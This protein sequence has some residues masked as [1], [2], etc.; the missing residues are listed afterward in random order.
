[1]DKILFSN[2]DFITNKIVNE[3]SIE[4]VEKIEELNVNCSE[5]K[6][7]LRRC[8]IRLLNVI[9]KKDDKCLF[10]TD[11]IPGFTILSL[12]KNKQIFE[13]VEYNEKYSVLASVEIN[14][15]SKIMN[16]YVEITGNR[17]IFIEVDDVV[18]LLF[19]VEDTKKNL[20][21]LGFYII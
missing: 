17:V 7:G 2:I 5:F 10:F 6:I 11:L 16:K 18:L 1:M 8:I 19:P 20:E 21:D 9:N 13:N 12:K 4:L 14:N 15:A 3:V